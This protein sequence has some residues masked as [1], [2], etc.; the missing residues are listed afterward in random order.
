MYSKICNSNNY[1]MRATN[2]K[3]P[4]NVVSSCVENSQ[5]DISCIYSFC[6]CTMPLTPFFFF[7]FP[8]ITVHGEKE[9]YVLYKL[10]ACK[11]FFEI[12]SLFY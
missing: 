2:N 5:L 7:F 3:L 12:I 6:K 1:L 8:I 10:E 4:L 11:L 9:F